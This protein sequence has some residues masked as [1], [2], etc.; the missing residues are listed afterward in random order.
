MRDLDS[1]SLNILIVLI[2]S[3]VLEGNFDLS[4]LTNVAK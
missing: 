3:S 1:C 2:M 4:N